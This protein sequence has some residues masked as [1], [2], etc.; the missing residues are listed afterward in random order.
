TG[1]VA[2]ALALAGLGDEALM[3]MKSQDVANATAAALDAI[4][5]RTL[6]NYPAAAP[7]D[8]VAS[9]AVRPLGDTGG[10][11][12]S[13]RLSAAPISPLVAI[14]AAG[15][16]FDHLPAPVKKPVARV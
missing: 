4:P 7:P 5:T 6:R 1:T 15:W 11:A 12:W 14:T 13:H 2:D 16:G 9:A 3:V 10:V 8:A